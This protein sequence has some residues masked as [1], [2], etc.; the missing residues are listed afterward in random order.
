M[1]AAVSHC[2]E[3]M[4]AFVWK[5]GCASVLPESVPRNF[6]HLIFRLRLFLLAII[7]APGHGN[8]A[9]K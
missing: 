3:F 8:R 2:V 5:M 9:G 4:I 7:G 6:K 1:A